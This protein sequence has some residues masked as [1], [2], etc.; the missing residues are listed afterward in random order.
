M[1]VRGLDAGIA[2]GG[3]AGFEPAVGCN[4]RRFKSAIFGLIVTKLMG[5]Y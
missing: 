3:E 5:Y 4:P 2:A 1:G